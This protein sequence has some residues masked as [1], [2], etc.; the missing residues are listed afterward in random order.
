MYPTD[1]YLQW[2]E[3]S[4]LTNIQKASALNHECSH[5]ADWSEPTAEGSRIVKVVIKEIVTAQDAQSF[6][7]CQV[8]YS[9]MY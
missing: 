2:I 3:F 7:F 5:T 6:D 4:Q 9:C 1:S 8:I